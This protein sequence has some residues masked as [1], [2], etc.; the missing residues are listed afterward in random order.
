MSPPWIRAAIL[1]C[2]PSAFIDACHAVAAGGFSHVEVLALDDRPAEHLAALGDTGLFVACASLGQGLT[3]TDV[4]TRRRQLERQERQVADAAQL[5]AT[6]VYLTPPV[7]QE[8]QALACFAEGCDLLAR[9]AAGR[10][11]RLAVMPAART[12]LPDLTAALAWLER[13]Q[14]IDLALAQ[15]TVEDFQRAGRRLGHVRLSDAAVSVEME[16]ALREVDYRGVVAVAA[17]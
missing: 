15:P 14:G 11:V 17:P 2:D 16:Q 8:Q 10:M 7:G 4:D 3:A 9:F 12:C 5:G 1:P 6:L 13:M